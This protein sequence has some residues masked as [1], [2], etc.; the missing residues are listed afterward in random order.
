MTWVTSLIVSILGG[1]SSLLLA[2]VIANACVSWYHIPSREGASGYF[3]VFVALGGG[4]A[5]LVVSFI[6]AQIAASV[7]GPGFLK[8]LGSA[9]GVV[10]LI[11]GVTVTI[12]RL[13]AHVPPTI[14]GEELNLEVEFRFPAG[15]GGTNPPTAEGE[16]RVELDP[17]TPSNP[18]KGYGIGE[19]ETAA[20]RFENKQWIVP[21]KMPLFT[22]RGKRFVSLFKVG[23]QDGAGFLLPVPRQPGKSFEQWSEW[24]PKQQPNGQPWPS[25]KMSCRFRVQ[26]MPPPPPPRDYDAEQAAAKEAEFA[27]IPPDAPLSRWL[28]YTGY[29][30][31][32]T[33]R[34]LQAIAK[35][36]NLVRE[37]E[38]L[39]LSED[40]ELACQAIRCV[41]KLPPPLEQF[42]A[43]MQ[44]VGQEIAER[45]RKVNAVSA[46]Q[47][48]S[49][50]GAANVSQRFTAWHQT[51]CVLREKSGGDFTPELRTILELSRIRKDSQS[52]QMDICRVASF[53]LHEWAGDAPLPSDPKPR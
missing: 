34:A 3:V 50:E 7:F 48:P 22:A 29:P 5:G 31:P 13:L 53:Y 20:A 42:N 46:E 27:A 10:L 18:G 37:I 25:D 30:Q 12:C 1:L 44:R 17:L 52:M 49:Y 40:N 32:Q 47:D 16:W 23:S 6:V 4:V 28:A 26:I 38:E 11:T 14:D 36:P 51:I 24:F 41:G 33:E 43:P 9:I 39:S 15:S 21:T 8:A 45:I 19:I 2:G 35:R